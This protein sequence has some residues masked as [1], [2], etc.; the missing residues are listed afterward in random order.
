[1]KTK[2]NNDVTDRIGF[3]Y[4]KNDIKLSEP[5]R[6]GA[7]CDESKENNNVIDRIGLVYAENHSRMSKPFR[8]SAVCDETN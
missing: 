8:P 3:V 7:I 1:M 4:V 5:I 6:S 2:Q